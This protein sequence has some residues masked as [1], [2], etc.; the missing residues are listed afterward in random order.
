MKK[1]LLILLFNGFVF[2]AVQAKLLSYSA[3]HIYL[4]QNMQNISQQN[5]N[6]LVRQIQ[7]SSISG[8]SKALIVDE[9]ALAHTT[10]LLATNK[11]GKIIGKNN[12]SRQVNKLF[13]NIE[14]VHQQADSRIDD[15]VKINVYMSSDDIMPKIQKQLKLKF[16]KSARPAVS[17]VRGDLAHADADIAMDVIATS[18]LHTGGKVNYF[19]SEALY[20]KSAA[21]HVSVLP[22]G[23][24]TYISGQADAG[25]LTEATR[26]T[27]KQLEG[28]LKH[29]GISKDQVV[30]IKSFMKPLTDVSIVEKEYAHFFEGKTVPPVV[31]VDW[32]SQNPVIEIELIAASPEGAIKTSEQLSFITPPGMTSSPVYSKVSQINHG[33]KIYISALYGSTLNDPPTQTAEIFA[34]LKELLTLAGSDFTQLAKATYYVSDDKASLSLNEIRPKFYDPKRPPAASKAMVKGIGV[35]GMSINIDMIG[36][37]R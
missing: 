33:K 27:L 19:R 15:I 3:M 18:D 31:Y 11:K 5:D 1:L 14:L 36:V 25:D 10:Q 16:L 20:D 13:K 7:P 29:L 8:S 30:Q 26:G 2:S 6:P 4:Q 23:G 34:S 32:L 22:A 37:V 9:V 24:V 12:I 35:H 17:F 28:T 21:A